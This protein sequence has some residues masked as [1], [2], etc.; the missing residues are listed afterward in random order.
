MEGELTLRREQ[1]MRRIVYRVKSTGVGPISLK[2]LLQKYFNTWWCDREPA[3]TE[4]TQTRFKQGNGDRS[5][6]L[7]SQLH[8]LLVGYCTL[9]TRGLTKGTLQRGPLGNNWFGTV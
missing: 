5:V 9:I 7:S 3:L 6:T 4:T 2:V 1:L 8:I